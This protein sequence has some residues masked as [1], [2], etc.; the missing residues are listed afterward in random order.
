[1]LNMQRRNN[2][3]V[4]TRDIVS[5]PITPL[6]EGVYALDPAYHDSFDKRE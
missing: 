4:V 6:R 3:P 1:M 5:Q 2:T